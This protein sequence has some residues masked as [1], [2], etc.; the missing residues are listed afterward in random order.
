MRGRRGFSL[1]ESVAVVGLMGVLAAMGS[2]RVAELARTARL[3]GAARTLGATLR[4]AR[5]QAL[6]GAAPV[7][8]VFDAAT[9]AYEV[10]DGAGVRLERHRLPPGVA[11]VGLPAR[12]RIAFGA[13]GTADNGTI[14][15]AAG[16]RTRQVIVNQRGRV[17]LS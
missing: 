16:D 15:L 14:R 9:G 1:V 10:L 12:A 7:V 8:A 17:R 6:A 3:A 4:L 11:F 13:L 5:G 2:V